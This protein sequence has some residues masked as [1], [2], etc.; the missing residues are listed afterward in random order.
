[1]FSR[2]SF[3]GR[4]AAVSVATRLDGLKLLAASSPRIAVIG[5]GAFGG[6]TAFHLR[7]LG[8]DVTLIDSWGPGNT[9]SSSGG[10]TRVIRAIYGADRVYAEMVKRA[11]EWWE[12]L[13]ATVD[14]SLYIET[15]VLWMHRGDDGYVR[16]SLP[17]LHDLGFGVDQIPL[18]DA[19]RR[20]PQIKF[21]GI[22]SVWFERRGGALSARRACV[23]VRDAFEKAGG[24]YRTA[25]ATP[26][27]IKNGTLASVQLGDGSHLE[28]DVF[29]FACGP[30][31][32]RF[33]P[34]VIG[35]FIRPTRQEVFYFGTPAGSSRYTAGPLPIWVDFGERI[36]YGV[37]DVK[38]RGFKVA[39]DTRGEPFDPT[40][41]QR[42]FTPA[43]LEE[44][45][46]FIAKRFPALKDA[47]L[48]ESRVCQYENS[49]DQHF[50][51][52]RHP[53]AENVWIVG[54]GSGHGF[55]HGPALGEYVAA[56]VLGK[57]KPDPFFQIARFKK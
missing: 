20:Y 39:D 46:K 6:W 25:H 34:D 52:D 4:V 43:K 19:Q 36:I 31:L 41:D 37:P 13:D 48:V 3:L 30:W 2:R 18:A 9:R 26:G 24:T 45:R 57:E 23:A 8:A 32:S 29:V 15:G 42:I 12:Q 14:E 22:K 50:I 44:A 27:A 16:S 54:G 17:I 55:K 11:Y 53:N 49:P 28:A 33:F 40:N 7:R 56:L 35:Q 1:M 47:P 51:I 5:A 38:G 21:D 10:E